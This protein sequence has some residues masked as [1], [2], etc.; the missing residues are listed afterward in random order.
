MRAAGAAPAML[1]DE[2]KE[3]LQPSVVERLAATLGA[4]PVRHDD[5]AD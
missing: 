5:A 2:V 1:L 3:G 4:R